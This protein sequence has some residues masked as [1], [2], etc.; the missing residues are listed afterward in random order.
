M[1]A[2]QAREPD[3]KELPFPIFKKQTRKTNY[4]DHHDLTIIQNA[5]SAERYVYSTKALMGEGEGKN[6]CF[7]A[8]GLDM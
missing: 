8:K 4:C 1:H 5:L 7:D 6:A 2:V 3:S